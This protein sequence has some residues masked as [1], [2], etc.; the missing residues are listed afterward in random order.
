MQYERLSDFTGKGPY[1]LFDFPLYTKVKI[2]TSVET[3]NEMETLSYDEDDVPEILYHIHFSENS[4][5]KYLKTLATQEKNF[6]YYCPFCKRELQII[7]KGYEIEN[8]LLDSSLTTYSYMY[9]M[10]EEFE[11]YDDHAAK[12]S[13]KK[14]KEFI[15]R[16]FDENRVLQMN[17]ECTSKD[18]HKF[19]VIF[20]LTDDNYLIKTGQYPSI[21]DFDN[22]LKEYKKVLKDKSVT[23][24]LTNAEILKTHNMGVGAFLYLRRIF[25]KLIFE[26][27][28]QAKLENNIDKQ[29]FNESK[30]KD[31]VKMLHANGYVPNYLAEINP[32]IYAI[33]SKGVHQ[34]SEEECNLHYDTLKEAILLILEEKVEMERKEKL[35]KGTKNELNKIHTKLSQ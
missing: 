11:E 31:K 7:H 27:F 12:V 14:F 29:A 3:T 24:E 18:K 33:L 22:S 34:L 20:Q 30:T 26:Q 5:V 8:E 10:S 4:D 17:L 23:K 6:Y 35:K 13:V 1:L 25:E 15:E 2:N 21:L 28:E 16:I 32:F 9:S 19:Y